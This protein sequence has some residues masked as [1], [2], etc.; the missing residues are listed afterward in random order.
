MRSSRRVRTPGTVA[1]YLAIAA[2]ALLLVTMP[3][4]GPVQDQLARAHHGRPTSVATW[5]VFQV[6]PKMYSF[7]HR[8]DERTEPI[9]DPT[10]NATWF[11][12]YPIRAVRFENA[13]ADAVARGDTYFLFYSGYQGARWTSR[14]VV[15]VHGH[16]LVV[17]DI[18]P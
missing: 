8:V 17:E 5:T 13:R 3:L 4:C 9:A 18:T 11:N 7:V 6:V 1:L 15:H 10:P 16:D 12:H 2:T 14:F